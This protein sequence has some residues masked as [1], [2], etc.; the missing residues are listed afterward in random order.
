LR[1]LLD[2]QI[3]SWFLQSRKEQALAAAAEKVPCSVVEEVRE[4]LAADRTRGGLFG[5]WFPTSN[6][7]L[8]EIQMGSPADDVH[9]ALSA[10]STTNRG[11]GE[12]AS[13]A[14]ASADPQLSFVSMDNGALLI[15][16]NELWGSG[17][18]V[19]KLP[20]F[21]RRLF[22]ASALSKE[23]ADAVMK[24]SNQILPTWWGRWVSS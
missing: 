2:T 16:L 24:K 17:E 20:A 3:V 22:D 21:L 23:T 7:Q 15:A 10:S 13:I 6:I 9:N 18:R 12:R 5:K 19:L 4:E 8:I 11:R 1:Y 14:V